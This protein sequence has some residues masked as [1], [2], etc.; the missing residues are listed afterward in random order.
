[1]NNPRPLGTRLVISAI[2]AAAFG[3]VG[4]C[5]LALSPSFPAHG[6]STGA[7]DWKIAVDLLLRAASLPL[8]RPGPSLLV[9]LGVAMVSI[10]VFF[11]SSPT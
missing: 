8:D 11:V 4:F 3:T 2:C 5:K 9:S 10:V 1:M 7:D 6:P